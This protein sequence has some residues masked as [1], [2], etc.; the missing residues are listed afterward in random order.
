MSLMKCT[1]DKLVVYHNK[2]YDECM[3]ALAMFYV[4]Y[5]YCIGVNID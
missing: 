2:Y 3:A 4:L 5:L 1:C